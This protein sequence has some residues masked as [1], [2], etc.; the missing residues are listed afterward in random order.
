MGLRIVRSGAISGTDVAEAQKVWQVN[1]SYCGVVRII[2]A[3]EFA[4]AFSI[5]A[6]LAILAMSEHQPP[7]A[8]VE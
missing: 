2:E 1:C 7:Q 5:L 8:G 3:M 4:R 6:M